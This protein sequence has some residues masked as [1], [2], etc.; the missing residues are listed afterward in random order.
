MKKKFELTKPQQQKL[1]KLSFNLFY[2]LAN[3]LVVTLIGFTF[4][5]HQISE[6]NIVLVYLLGVILTT[7]FIDGY[8][9]GILM[10]II[11]TFTFNYFFT[12][13]HLTFSVTDPQYIFTFAVML[14]TALVISTL[15]ARVKRTAAKA[16]A[17]EQEARA[18]Y[19]LTTHLT[20][21]KT[22]E[23]IVQISLKTI[24]ELFQCQAACLCF[25]EH[26][27]PNKSFMQHV[28]ADKV[29]YRKVKNIEIIRQ[30]LD[31][32]LVDDMNELEFFDWPI[33]GQ[34]NNLG[35]IRLP[36][37][38]ANAL[39]TDQRQLLNSIIESTALAMDRLRAAK[40]Q[41]KTREEAMQERYRGN[42]LRAVSH[43]LRTPLSSI[44][45][46][47]EMLKSMMTTEDQQ[48][49]FVDHIH[50]DS[51]WLHQLV[52]NILNLTR[53][54]DGKL[55]LN[56]QEE[57]I[58]E[59]IGSAVTR[60]LKTQP[61]V[62]I[63]VEIPDELLFVPMDAKLIEQVLINLLDNA[64]KHTD[65]A[66]EILVCAKKES[67][68]IKISVSDRGEGIA[69]RDLPYIFEMFYTTHEGQGDSSQGIG[70]GLAICDT[71]VT[72]HGGKIAASNRTDAK[73]GA[74][75]TFTLPFE[76]ELNEAV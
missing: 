37:E 60:V 67:E 62:D 43:D 20:E 25:N 64:I 55:N 19:R 8:Y 51:V 73:G 23:D 14:L 57:T 39:S 69:V 17:R 66:D 26:G 33:S 22:T 31:G 70:L 36:K 54:Q 44:M 46:T 4:V 5:S 42:L 38:T 63:Q 18:L 49:E 16:L 40:K 11:S 27:I 50:K 56:K 7:R 52:E 61:H 34:K 45:G 35:L 53:L 30:R 24:S 48:Y 41:I 29:V 12:D 68:S 2:M 47:C 1:K 13:P 6:T 9:F 15:T 21:A 58:E 76:G 10:S 74:C 75:F 59:V 3:L 65:T 72:A 71:I 28:S 32:I